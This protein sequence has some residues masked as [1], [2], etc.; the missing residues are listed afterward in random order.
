[1]TSFANDILPLFT[2]SQIQCMA[3][4]GVLLDDFAYMSDTDGDDVYLDHAAARHVYAR[5]TGTTE[6]PRMPLG[7]PFWAQ[8]KLDLFQSWIDE[9]FLP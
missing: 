5:L 7:G 2:P 3:G 1:M 8:D 4:K 6:G 9:G